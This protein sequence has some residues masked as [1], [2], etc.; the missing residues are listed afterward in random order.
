MLIPDVV[1]FTLGEA[2]KLL[3]LSGIDV[4]SIKVT[5]PPR[6]KDTCFDANFRVIRLEVITDNKVEVLVCKPLS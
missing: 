6:E 5:S 1:G 4:C 3:D 2:K